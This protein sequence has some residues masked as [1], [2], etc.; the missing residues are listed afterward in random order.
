MRNFSYG[1]KGEEWD[2]YLFN[3]DMLT[4]DDMDNLCKEELKN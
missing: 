4:M 1:L 2:C 3:P